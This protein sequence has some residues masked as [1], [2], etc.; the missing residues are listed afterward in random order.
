MS[1]EGITAMMGF[2][3]VYMGAVG[4]GFFLGWKARGLG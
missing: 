1:V 4:L 3:A 2:V